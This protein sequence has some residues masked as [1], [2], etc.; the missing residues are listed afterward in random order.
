MGGTVNEL[1]GKQPSEITVDSCLNVQIDTDGVDSF[2]EPI[3]LEGRSKLSLHLPD[4]ITSTTITL[5]GANFSSRTTSDAN[6]DFKNG[7]K[8]PEDADFNDLFDDTGTVVT[9]AATTGERIYNLQ[10]FGTPLWI[11][12]NFSVTEV[13]TAHLTA[14]G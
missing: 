11:R 5:Q 1:L 9:L 13:R 4:A 3:L 6:A 7:F 8:I 10:D 12:F 2:S 14:K